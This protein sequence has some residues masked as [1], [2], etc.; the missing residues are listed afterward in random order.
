MRALFK[1]GFY[2]INIFERL[3]LSKKFQDSQFPE[4]ESFKHN[5]KMKNIIFYVHCKQ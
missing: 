2:F 3:K 4:D 1:I 5:S